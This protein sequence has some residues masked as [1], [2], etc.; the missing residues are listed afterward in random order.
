M[1]AV[2]ITV[3]SV[4][5]IDLHLGNEL[6]TESVSAQEAMAQMTGSAL[7]QGEYVGLV[8]TGVGPAPFPPLPTVPTWPPPAFP[9]G[10]Y[11][12]AYDLNRHPAFN[13]TDGNAIFGVIIPNIGGY[14]YQ[15]IS[16]NFVDPPL[17]FRYVTTILNAGYDATAPYSASAT[18]VYSDIVNRHASEYTDSKNINIASLHAVYRL[19]MA[20]DSSNKAQWD[21]MMTEPGIGL[22]PA[23]YDY[24]GLRAFDTTT[25]RDSTQHLQ[26]LDA[27]RA[28]VAIGNIAAECVI[29]GRANDGF[30]NSLDGTSYPQ[31]GDTTGYKPVNLATDLN[32]DLSRWQPQILTVKDAS[33]NTKS[34]TQQFITPQWANT[35]PYTVDQSTGQV[36]DPRDYRADPPAKSNYDANMDAY[37]A[38]ARYVAAQTASLT[39]Y[40]KYVAEYFDNKARE[41]LFFPAVEAVP[42]AGDSELLVATNSCPPPHAECLNTRDFWQ[43]DFLLHLAQFDA[44]IVTWQEKT[45]HDAVRPITAIQHALADETFTKFDGTSVSG[46]DW[47]PYLNTGDHPEYP[48]ATACFCAAQAAAWRLHISDGAVT[49]DYDAIKPVNGQPGFGGELQ[50]R[51]SVRGDVSG[52]VRIDFKTWFDGDDSYVNTCAKSRVW[53]GVHF[54]DAV[55]AS[56]PICKAVGEKAYDYFQTLL[57]GTAELRAP[58]MALLPDPLLRGALVCR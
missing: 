8:P 23:D 43:L 13:M 6:G 28:A 16:P 15:N 10:T 40:E 25:C 9:P 51:H 49:S 47:K 46:S 54:Q 31:F 44:G 26:G 21:T 3:G 38:Q 2:A 18:G 20:F 57:D 48:S 22:D 52:P 1:L 50:P 29:E 14:I 7:F 4:L 17:A 56:V 30:N 24:F 55:E 45:R 53:A 27:E 34:I 37:K 42:P 58:S 32:P 39:D 12:P 36:L 11:D 5:A 19:A 33:G 35:E 41:T